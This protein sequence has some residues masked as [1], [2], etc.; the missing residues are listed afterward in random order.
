MRV[1]AKDLVSIGA[2]SFHPTFIVLLRT[3]EVHDVST[4]ARP[5]VGL[6]EIDMKDVNG[7]GGEF[8]NLA[9]LDCNEERSAAFAAF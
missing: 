8:R 4:T 7:W 2:H 3:E 9:V 1:Q 6:I 5:V